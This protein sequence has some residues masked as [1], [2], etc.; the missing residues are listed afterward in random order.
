MKGKLRKVLPLKVNFPNLLTNRL[1]FDIIYW[2]LRGVAQLV[3]RLVRDQEAAGSNPVTST[4]K[5]QTSLAVV[6]SFLLVVRTRARLCAKRRMRV[7]ISRS[8]IDK[9]ACQAQS[10]DIFAKGENPAFLPRFLRR[11]AN[12]VCYSAVRMRRMTQYTASG[13][14][15]QMRSLNSLFSSGASS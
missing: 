15:L 1:R 13:I 14:R 12:I 4:K 3:A 7:R 6:C 5:E 11:L 8:K 2:H 10:E 9:L